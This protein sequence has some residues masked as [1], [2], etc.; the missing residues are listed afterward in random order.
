MDIKELVKEKQEKRIRFLIQIYKLSNGNIRQYVPI[1]SIIDPIGINITE[2]EN[3][4]TDL[5]ADDLITAVM[6]PE[7]ALTNEGRRYVEECI[8]EDN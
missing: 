8:E 5:I 2:Y 1:R 6:G 3:I 7:F 4:A